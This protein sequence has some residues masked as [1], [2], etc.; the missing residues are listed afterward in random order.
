MKIIATLNTAKNMESIT[1]TVKNCMNNGIDIFRVNLGKY[2]DRKD[3]CD[4]VEKVV[5]LQKQF[6][7]CIM[8]DIPYPYSKSRIFINGKS[9]LSVKKNEKLKLGNEKNCIAMLVP[10]T[11]YRRSVGDLIYISDMEFPFI[12]NAIEETYV[13]VTALDDAIIHDRKGVYG[14][15][16]LERSDYLLEDLLYA[17]NIINPEYIAFSFLSDVASASKFTERYNKPVEYIAKIETQTAMDNIFNICK[18][19]NLMVARGDLMHFASKYLLLE[20]QNQI[21]S[22]AKTE[23]KK[24]YVATGIMDNLAKQ[25]ELSQAEVCDLS[26]IFHSSVDGIVLSYGVVQNNIHRASIVMRDFI[27]RG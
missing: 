16:M 12:I 21:V 13:E 5:A 8:L 2:V 23:H 22:A 15:G 9:V 11:L 27:R 1:N 14:E 7:I 25:N 18:V 10:D 26:H 6:N 24:C 4:V 17:A 19:Y 20:N 3:L